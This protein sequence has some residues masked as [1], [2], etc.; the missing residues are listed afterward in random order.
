MKFFIFTL[1]LNFTLFNFTNL[2]SQQLNSVVEKHR[3]TAISIKNL[4]MS[5]PHGYQLLE[6]LVEFGPR[7]SGSENLIN[8][9]KFLLELLQ[10]YGFDTVYYQNVEA[11][12]WVRGNTE[13]L[14]IISPYIEKKHLT[15][16]SL[17]NSVGTNDEEINAPVILFE[18]FDQLEE[19]KES[20]KG[21]IVF[22]NNKY[23]QTLLNTFEGYSKAVRYRV[24]GAWRAAKYGAKAVLIRS[25]TTSFDNVPHTGTLRYIDTIPKIPGAALG[26]QDAEFLAS[27]IQNSG[28]VVL[29][30]N[31]S[32]EMKGLTTVKNIIAEI[33]GSSK[34][35][36]I[37]LVGGHIDSWD[38]GDGSHD[39]GGGCMQSIDVL[40]IFKV[41]DIKPARTI[42][43]VLFANEENGLRGALDY[44][45]N[46]KVMGE[47]H[48]AAIESDAGVFTP[49]G[50]K[51]KTDSLTL[52][53]L[54]SFLPLLQLTGIEW[55]KPGGGGA[56]INQIPDVRAYI[57]YSPDEQRYFDLHHSDNDTFDK[58]NLREM[59]LGTAAMAILT[60]LIS[61]EG[62]D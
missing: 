49:R 44:G 8:A 11:P 50:F 31:L 6:K 48:I 26:V 13:K 54:Q 61:E 17:G 3:E 29:S 30:L 23:D 62:L 42:R 21:K 28:E 25:V 18:S 40:R 56:D 46:S 20:V 22:F 39:D 45:K 15:I 9:E 38:L 43:C 1:F 12:Y 51:A 57:G 10:N 55:V 60:F 5:D 2:Y 27:L 19:A 53:K 41:L 52:I 58:V 36:E 24:D 14:N 33:R 47:N 35:D 37:V 32:C 4:A 59:Q 16:R 34:P 7:L